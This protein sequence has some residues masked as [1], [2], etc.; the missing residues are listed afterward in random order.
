[1]ST[2]ITDIA[3]A[4]T[5]GATDT[6]L[7]AVIAEFVGSSA[8]TDI[9]AWREEHYLELRGWAYPDPRVR[10]D[11]DVK[12]AN[13]ET[14]EGEAQLAQYYSDCWAVKARFPKPEE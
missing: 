1:M 3:R 9:T 14:T 8:S 13:G 11:A 4:V 6:E 5:S 2:L 7:N 10:F 12:I